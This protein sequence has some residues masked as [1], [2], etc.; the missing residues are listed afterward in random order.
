[1]VALLNIQHQ[2]FLNKEV[3][4]L[5]TR[6][7]RAILRKSAENPS[8]MYSMGLSGKCS[9]DATESDLVLHRTETLP[10][11]SGP[12]SVFPVRDMLQ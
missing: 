3:S 11:L 7:D 9:Q 6:N 10:N 2:H 12:S 5:K 8:Q 1:M 4:H